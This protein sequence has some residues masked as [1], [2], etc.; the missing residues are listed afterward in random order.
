MAKRKAAD[1]VNASA[2]EVTMNEE[3]PSTS[4]AISTGAREDD[5]EV[6][7]D[8]EATIASTGDAPAFPPAPASAGQA[9]LKSE[10]RRI[11]MP[12]HRMT[13]LKKE[14]INIFGPLT[15]MLG[16]QVRMNVPRKAVEVR[17][18]IV[19]FTHNLI[20]TGGQARHRSIQRIPALFR[21]AQTLSKHLHLDL[22]STYGSELICISCF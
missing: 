15:E 7:I 17:V 14:W 12:P 6:M 4:T 9:L 18:R 5:D 11:P 16:L 2:D 10:T 22:M 19:G 13:P 3:G 8:T 1:V 21:K 20:H